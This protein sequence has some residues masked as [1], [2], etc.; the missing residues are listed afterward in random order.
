MLD[1]SFSQI[2]L[3]KKIKKSKL[4]YPLPVS[5]NPDI[6]FLIQNDL[7]KEQY[8]PFTNEETRQRQQAGVIHVS[9]GAVCGYEITPKG[10]AELDVYTTNT[11]RWRITTG[12][13]WAAL[14]LSAISII[15]QILERLFEV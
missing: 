4:K 7:I 3:L 15:W 11:V 1:L 9:P 13:A 5:H 12:I 2:K 6:A 10:N 14:I 8:R